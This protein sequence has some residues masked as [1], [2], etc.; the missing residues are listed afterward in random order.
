[1][2]TMVSTRMPSQIPPAL[3]RSMVLIPSLVLFECSH[4]RPV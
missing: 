2:A 3:S 1:M 4:L